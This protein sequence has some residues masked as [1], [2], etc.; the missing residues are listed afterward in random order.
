[1]IKCKYCENEVKDEGDVCPECQARI[2]D[3]YAQPGYKGD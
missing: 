3:Y 1:M 2:A